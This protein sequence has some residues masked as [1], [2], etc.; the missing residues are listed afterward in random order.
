M[1]GREPRLGGSG[2]IRLGRVGERIAEAGYV[3]D[4]Y[5]V[6]A[7]NWRCRSGEIDLVLEGGGVVV[8]CEVK[9]R[10]SDAFGHP[11][12]AVDA[13]RIGRLR[14]AATEWLGAEAGRRRVR[15]D[16]VAV[17]PDRVERL[18]GAF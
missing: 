14:R 6:L 15:F 18:E 5:R 1:G 4:G 12:E 3:R 9:A 8:F 16:V 2:H 7:R 11:A 10:R 17:L 13:R